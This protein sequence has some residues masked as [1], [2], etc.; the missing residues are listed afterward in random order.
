MLFE[1][2]LAHQSMLRVLLILKILSLGCPVIASD[3]SINLNFRLSKNQ[4]IQNG[5]DHEVGYIN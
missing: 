5:E 3:T 4:I 2:R 1:L